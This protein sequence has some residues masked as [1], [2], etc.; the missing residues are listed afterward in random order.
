M[1]FPR[2]TAPR[3]R[4]GDL[5]ELRL[6]LNAPVVSTDALPPGPARAAIALVRG[7]SGRFSLAIGVRSLRTGE[8]A[9]FTPE[10]AYPDAGAAA[11][12][13]D[14]ALSF[15]E[16]MGFLFDD[17]ELAAGAPDA[18]DRAF[19]RWCELLGEPHEE[20]ANDTEPAQ[21]L[22][23]PDEPFD[24]VLGTAASANDEAAAPFEELVLEDAVPDETVLADPVPEA[25]IFDRSDE[26]LDEAAFGLEPDAP[27]PAAT[28]V[29]VAAPVAAPAAAPRLPLTKFRSVP[30]ANPPATSSA[31]PPQGRA[32]LITKHG[33]ALGRLQ[34][35]KRRRDPEGASQPS[36]LQ[37]LL[38]SF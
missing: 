2:S 26:T 27:L 16:G 24:L 23:D 18:R 20:P 33:P 14:A 21:P 22:A 25:S 38:G 32:V 3:L 29:A 11:V 1:F 12:G 19:A 31:A 17:D 28:A 13:V 7:K 4:E 8:T 30:Q 10:D 6:S 37:R 9:V 15:A 36:W 35:V 5:A 34:L